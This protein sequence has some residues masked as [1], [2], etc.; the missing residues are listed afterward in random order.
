MITF[1]TLQT[2]KRITGKIKKNLGPGWYIVE[3]IQGR[4]YK[5]AGNGYRVGQT[6]AAINGQIVD[7]AGRETSPPVFQV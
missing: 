7:T 4:K 1:A 2:D 6:I 3:D 5:M